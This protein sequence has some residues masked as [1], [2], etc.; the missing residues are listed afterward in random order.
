ME[1]LWRKALLLIPRQTSLQDVLILGF[2]AGGSLRAIYK[3][4]PKCSIIS[5]EH[6]PVMIKIATIISPWI[7]N[8]Q[9]KII[10]ADAKKAAASLSE[11][12]DLILFD[13]YTGESPS[14]LIHDEAFLKNLQKRLNKNGYLL[15]NMFEHKTNFSL[16][17][18]FFSHIKNLMLVSNYFAL[19][20]HPNHLT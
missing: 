15:V 19:Y 2:G 16:F 1:Y 17:D 10:L 3:R 4:F 5:V 14:P 8:K 7:K 20:K 11:T 6:D 13:L 12:F 18:T 9:H